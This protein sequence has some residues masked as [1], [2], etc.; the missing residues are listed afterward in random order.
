MI[1][2]TT[3]DHYEDMEELAEKIGDLQ[4]D[5][6][7]EFLAALNKKI[8]S[9]G[10]KDAARGRVQ[11]ASELNQLA[12]HLAEGAEASQRAWVICEPFM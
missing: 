4:Y 3:I 11:L 2:K 10:A 9:D 7:A 12:K 1:H 6:L 5:A 8:A